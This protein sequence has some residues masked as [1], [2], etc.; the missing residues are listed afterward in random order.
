MTATVHDGSADPL[1]VGSEAIESGGIEQDY[2]WIQLVNQQR[3]CFVPLRPQQIGV[4]K[5]H[6]AET[7]RRDIKWA[8][9]Q[10]GIEGFM[11]R[12]RSR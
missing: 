4:R 9:L 5:L 2:A 10:T 1:F 11:I 7:E 6:A 12:A 3:F 8:D